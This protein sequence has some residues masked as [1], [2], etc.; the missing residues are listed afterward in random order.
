MKINKNLLTLVNLLAFI[1]TIGV[2]YLSAT[3]PLNGKTP[4][5][6]S[7][8]YPNLFVPAG[9]TFS[10]W[11][12]IYLFL[13]LWI[14]GQLVSLIRPSVA[15]DENQQRVGWLFLSTS[16]LNI[17]WLFAWH[18][19]IVALSVL[20]MITLLYEL[21]HINRR[22]H[23]PEE[24]K[25][26][27]AWEKWV[28]FPA[29]GLYQGWITVALIAN[30]TAFLVSQGWSPEINIQVLLTIALMAVGALLAIYFVWKRGVTWHGFAVAWALY[31]IYA[32]RAALADAPPAQFTAIGLAGIVLVLTALQFFKDARTA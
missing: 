20:V 10:I 17:G 28:A 7:Q 15:I 6:L 23:N 8:L 25:T 30:A 19:Q 5:Q 22:L 21:F 3:L 26:S 9:F 18:W 12:A 27:S 16:I 32:Q 29:F 2:N 13:F 14:G 11:G 24:E 31:G 1:A 4:G